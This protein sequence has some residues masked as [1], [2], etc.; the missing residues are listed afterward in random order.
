MKTGNDKSRHNYNIHLKTYI[1]SWMRAYVLLGGF[2]G[3]FP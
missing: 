1:E 3:V 2:R